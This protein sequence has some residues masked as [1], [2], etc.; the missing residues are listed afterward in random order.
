MFN[1]VENAWIGARLSRWGWCV[2]CEAEWRPPE[3]IGEPWGHRRRRNTAVI[4]R[5]E[6][7]AWQ[8]HICFLL[9]REATAE[10]VHSIKHW[11]HDGALSQWLANLRPDGAPFVISAIVWKDTVIWLVTSIHCLWNSLITVT[12][13][14]TSCRFSTANLV[15]LR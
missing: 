5:H 14:S 8:Q 13:H 3:A 9:R 10:K 11:V 15:Y 7:G 1:T 4:T 12:L 6:M 2:N